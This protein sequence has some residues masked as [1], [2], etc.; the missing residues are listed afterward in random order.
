M[1]TETLQS[2]VRDV[3]DEHGVTCVYAALVGSRA[4]NTAH[5]GSDYD[6]QFVFCHDPMTYTD[7]RGH[8]T[9]VDADRDDIDLHGW[10]VRKFGDMLLDSNPSAVEFLHSSDAIVVGLGIP[11]LR[12]HIRD[13]FNHMALYHHYL[14]LAESN[15]RQYVENGNDRT[16][17]RQYHIVRAIARA[18]FIR[19]S[20]ELPPVD[21]FA[22]GRTDA[23]TSERNLNAT[24]RMCV[25]EKASG[26]GDME[27]RDVVGRILDR[28]SETPMD[29]TDE[30]T[31][32]PSPDVIGEWVCEA[33]RKS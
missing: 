19:V 14:S 33:V 15:Y 7:I 17:G 32:D 22:L 16:I 20:G 5:D 8:T 2:A 28:E 31:A 6:A 25:C 21:A 24:Y 27:Y 26:N 9:S 18:K 1:N 10:D 3:C 13:N 12:K 4:E 30:R 11:Q 23:V 29:V